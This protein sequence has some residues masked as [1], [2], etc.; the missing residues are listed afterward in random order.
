MSTSTRKNIRRKSS[1]G[2]PRHRQRGG[3]CKPVLLLASACVLSVDGLAQSW[4]YFAADAADNPQPG[5]AC[6]TNGTEWAIAVNVVGAGARLLKIVGRSATENAYLTD[7]NAGSTLD[8]RG[9]VFGSGESD[10]WTISVIAENALGADATRGTASAVVTPGTLVGDVAPWFR[11]ATRDADGD[12]HVSGYTSITIDEPNITGTLMSRLTPKTQQGLAWSIRVPN[13]ARIAAWSLAEQDRTAF[14]PAAS[15]LSEDGFLS[16]KAIEKDAFGHKRDWRGGLNLPVVET[17]GDHALGD[18]YPGYDE[19]RLGADAR[20][21]KTIGVGACGWMSEG[22]TNAVIGLAEGNTVGESAF[23]SLP[24]LRRVEFTGAPPNF[25]PGAA[26]VFSNALD[27]TFVVPP[28]AEWADFLTAS[29]G[30]ARWTGDEIRAYRTEHPDGPI[31]IGTVSP[32]VFRISPR[33]QNDKTYHL[34]VSDRV[35]SWVGAFDFDAAQGTVETEDF[36]IDDAAPF[37]VALRLT[38]HANAGATFAGWYGDVPD[39]KCADA[40][41]VVRE[42]DPFHANWVFVRFTRPWTLTAD[43]ADATKAVLDN[44][45]FKIQATVDPETRNLTLGR[46]TACSLYASG[47][48]GDGILDLGGTITDAAGNA[49]QIVSLGTKKSVLSSSA[50]DAVPGARA[51]V[52]PGTLTTVE[53]GQ[54]FHASDK[55]VRATYDSVVFDEPTATGGPSSWFFAGQ[56]KLRHVI[57]RCPSWTFPS[58]FDGLFYGTRVSETDV[59][60]W[61]LDGVK[62]FGTGQNNNMNKDYKDNGRKAW[63][64]GALKLPSVAVI[65]PCAFQTNALDEAWLGHGAAK[66]RVEEIKAGAFQASG[67]T[68]LVLNAARSLV[69]GENAFGDLPDLKAVT[70][71]GHVVSADAFAAILASATAEAPVAVYASDAYGWGQAPYLDAPTEAELFAAPTGETVLGVWRG[72][73]GVRA[74]VC[75]RDSPFARKGVLLLIR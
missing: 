2:N 45:H 25:A 6:I 48:T 66:T 24:R 4:R 68:N 23:Y 63:L 19:I 29:G 32:A 17:V 65:S 28:S 59:G 18:V 73:D 75:H 26:N 62:T 11:C 30:F 36:V 33:A 15:A 1:A 13:A 57:F 8:L 12:A 5:V 61:K 49:Y 22:V 46:G 53:A 35:S 43:D 47:N 21:V 37:N 42:A 72:S 70:F 31:V 10:T 71:L 55:T 67:L 64:K 44:G 16:V 27:M 58:A 41:L 3:F 34:A 40:T 52:T 20:S 56:N 38:A 39:G 60:W 51:L 69:V 74:W 54:L 9:R 7:P 14:P 50:N